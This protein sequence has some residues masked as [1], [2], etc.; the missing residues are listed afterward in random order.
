MVDRLK[1]VSG[2][3]AIQAGENQ[4]PP[5]L[6]KLVDQSDGSHAPAVYVVN[7]SG[8]GTGASAQQVQGNTADGVAA[9]GNPVRIGGVDKSGNVQEI[10]IDSSGAVYTY[11]ED[12]D[13]VGQSGQINLIN[14]IL[15]A[16]AGSAAIDVDGYR[17]GSIQLT[18]SGTVSSGQM[19]LECSNDNV[20]FHAIP[21]IIQNSTTAATA[22]AITP[23][24]SIGN[25]IIVFAIPGRYI[26]LR[27]SVAIGGGSV[28]ATSR[29]SQVPFA[30]TYLSAVIQ[31]T[32][33]A[34]QGNAAAA[35]TDTGNPI[36]IGAKY[37]S[38]RVSVT[39]GQRANIAIDQYGAVLSRMVGIGNTGQD[40]ISNANMTNAINYDSA[41]TNATIRLL[42]VAPH[43]YNGS[44]W[45]RP[46][47]DTTGA[48]TV[49]APSTGT[50]RSITASTT[51]QQLMAANSARHGFYIKNDT[52][53]DVWI[54][55]GA[56][57]V[58][59]AGGGNIK[60][61][62]NGGYF[63]SPAAVTPSAAINIIAASATP[64][65]TAREL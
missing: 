36:K 59:T 21:Y 47:G 53:I 8:G 33:F 20:T 63:E 24:S 1:Q 55:I 43:Y 29:F 12:L 45:D 10:S 19:L 28:Q 61:A 35:A 57:A 2:T 44:T 27:I 42:M 16:V 48:Y 65:I 51:S 9:V 41:S 22:A 52:A 64:A 56:T 31:N 40:G 34:V 7:S 6:Q 37:D 26:R 18:T 3:V 11:Q 50:D 14:N 32:T 39:D 5:V 49:A 25:S 38:T 62:A 58:A 4:G 30:P 23:Q 17:S 60:I 46:K 54:N 15:T 13:I